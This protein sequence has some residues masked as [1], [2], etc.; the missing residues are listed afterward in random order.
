[1]YQI[2][3]RAFEA[4]GPGYGAGEDAAGIRTPG[5]RDRFTPNRALMARKAGFSTRNVTVE[6]SAIAEAI[7]T[8]T[9]LFV[10]SPAFSAYMMMIWPIVAWSR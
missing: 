3:G 1:L 6:A 7:A 10:D 4:R 8:P 9:A 5:E 2:P